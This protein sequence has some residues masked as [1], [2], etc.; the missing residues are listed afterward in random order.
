MPCGLLPPSAPLRKSSSARGK[1]MTRQGYL[2]SLTNVAVSTW[3]AAFSSAPL[4]AEDGFGA[5]ATP[6][7]A[8]QVAAWEAFRHS[9][10]VEG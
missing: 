4:L 1:R 5:G 10:S 8:V 7:Q 3:R 2:L 9:D 6:W